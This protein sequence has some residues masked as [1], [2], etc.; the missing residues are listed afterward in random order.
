MG[1]KSQAALE[2]LTTYAWALVAIMIAIGALYYFGVFDFKKFLPQ[3]CLFP[4]QFE[5]ADF[6]FAGSPSNEVRFRLVNNIGEQVNVKSFSITNKDTAPIACNTAPASIAVNCGG[7]PQGGL[8]FNWNAGL[9]CDFTFTGCSGATFQK[10][11]RTDAAITMAYCATATPGC[12]GTS[13]ADHVVK[14]KIVAVVN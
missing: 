3:E 2:F 12:P 5:C 6:A 1:S 14:G 4:S 13:N 8:P 7:T 11:F 9:D 10:S